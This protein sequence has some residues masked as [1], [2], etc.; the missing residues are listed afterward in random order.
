MIKLNIK[1]KSKYKG[2]KLNLNL[3]FVICLSS[4]LMY[5]GNNDIKILLYNNVEYTLLL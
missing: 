5:S 1:R 2:L 4:H 3:T